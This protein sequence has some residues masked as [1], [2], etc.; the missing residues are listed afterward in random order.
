MSQLLGPNKVETVFISNASLDQQENKFK[1]IPEREKKK[2]T[3]LNNLTTLVRQL[4]YNF[5]F[6]LSKFQQNKEKRKGKQ[7]YGTKYFLF[8]CPPFSR[9]PNGALYEQ[10]E[11]MQKKKKN[12]LENERELLGVRDVYE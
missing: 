5:L 9:Q 10:K 12:D 3:Y 11:E 8:P 6:I 4:Q 1:N 2:K 7:I